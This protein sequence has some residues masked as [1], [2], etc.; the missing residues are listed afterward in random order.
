VPED[1]TPSADHE[2]QANRLRALAESAHQFAEATTDV[3]RLLEVVGR[4]CAELIGDGCYIRLLDADG[5]FLLPVATYHPD[6]EIQQFLRDTTDQISLR[7]GEGISGR[8]VETG[9]TVLIPHVPFDQYKK[10]TKPEFAA[11]FERIGVTSMIVVRLR[12]R[13]TNLGFI[14]LVRN[15]SGRPAYTEEDKLLVEDLA[16]RAALAIDAGRL[17][18]DLERRVL[19]RTKDLETANAELEA[20]S[21]SVSHDLRA[22]LRAIDGFSQI[23]LEDHGG[24]LDEEG[25]RVVGVIRSNTQRM[26]QLIDDL[27][28]LSQ[29]GRHA[30]RPE[31][32][33]MRPLVLTLFEELRASEPTRTLEL[34]VGELPEATC[35]YGLIRQVW[36]N[37]LGN[38]VKYTRGRDVATVDVEGVLERDEVRYTIRDNGTGFN[39]AYSDKL[40]KVFQ[41]LHTAKQ[42][43]GTGVGLAL[44][45]RIVSRHGGRV[46]AEGRPGEGATFGFALPKR[47]THE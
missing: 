16:D 21:Y 13:A 28:K 2:R 1:S 27:L 47:S 24:S 40:F 26:G 6:P 35:D 12:A 30:I 10:M 5:V 44:V 14:A 38:A 22:P 29:L 45:H 19:E 20:F 3:T 11:V 25:R 8:V 43:E 46:W 4:R 23:L 17:V 37:L 7:L 41:R 9:E 34:R 39:A 32:V 36:T 33:A 42:F 18:Q 15:G 31:Q